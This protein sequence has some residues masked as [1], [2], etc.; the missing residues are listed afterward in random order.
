MSVYVRYD[1][2]GNLTTATFVDY[3][4]PA[5]TGLPFF[6]LLETETPTA[7]NPLGAKGIGEAGAIGSTPAVV[8]AVCDALGR[9]DLQVPLTPEQI[10][11]AIR[12]NRE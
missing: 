3:L 5:A 8:N 9:Q 10:W 2:S 7:T 4:L 1:E 11:R 12:S 6:E